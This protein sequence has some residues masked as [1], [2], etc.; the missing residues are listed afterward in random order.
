MK[1]FNSDILLISSLHDFIPDKASA[2]I[3]NPHRMKNVIKDI[4]HKDFFFILIINYNS[5]MINDNLSNS[6]MQPA[7][8]SALEGSGWTSK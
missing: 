1:M 6:R 8:L 3:T 5:L 7:S 2:V 4:I